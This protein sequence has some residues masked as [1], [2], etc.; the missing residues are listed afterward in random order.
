MKI[1][2]DVA[3]RM[4]DGI[5]LRADVFRPDT[6]ENVPVVI[7][8]GPYGKGVRYQD[9][10]YK[11][12]WEWML[13]HHPD[14][15]PG[16]QQRFLAWETVDPETWVNW[17]YAV[18]RVD[19]R[20]AGRSPGRLEIFSPREARDFHD[21]IEWFGTRDWCNG[22]VGL[23]GISYYAI[24]QW[25][26][27]ALQPPHLAAMIP[28]EG[29]ADAYRDMFRHGGILS[30][31]FFAL[32]YQRQ[33]RSI[34]HGYPDA[35]LDPWLE[36]PSTGPAKLSEEDL[37][38]NRI[39]VP[40]N[41]QAREMDDEWYRARSTN[42]SQV[43]TPFLSAANWGGY[44]LHARG[45]FEAF[46]QAASTQK[47]LEC[48]PGKHEEWFYLDQGMDLQRRFFDHFLKGA[49]NGWEAEPSV[50]LHLRR[51]FSDEFELRR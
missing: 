45:N 24:N 25:R 37:F 32:W 11:A 30:N 44:G 39:D 36:S 4:E 3:I 10:T 50:F 41:A 29:A 46:T 38:A 27:A 16:S 22:K 34:Q 31:R 8:M 40:A 18:V 51:P 48:H 42:F 5:D 9:H 6:S 17:G 49:A 35:P 26:V 33:V 14:L 1:E 19:S 21:C 47:W 28:W 23:L 43:V 12:S 7:T 2:R 20:G 15:L 13:S